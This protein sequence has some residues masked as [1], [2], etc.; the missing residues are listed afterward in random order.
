M[1]EATTGVEM[2]AAIFIPLLILAAAIVTSH[3]II[4]HLGD[5]ITGATK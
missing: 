3:D 4:T 1:N 5:I 2:L